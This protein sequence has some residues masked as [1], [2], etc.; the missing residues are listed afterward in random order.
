MVRLERLD[1]ISPA[2]ETGAPRHRS[3]SVAD[4]GMGDPLGFDALRLRILIERHLLHTASARARYLLENWH[5]ALPRFI[6]VMPI[7][8][9]KALT[10]LKREK[11]GVRAVAAE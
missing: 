11:A 2:D 10:D 4:S 8:Y 6:K 3:L 7:D 5:S 9:A 1:L